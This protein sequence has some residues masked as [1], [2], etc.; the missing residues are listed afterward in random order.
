MIGALPFVLIFD[1]A[2]VETVVVLVFGSEEIGKFLDEDNVLPL[3]IDAD[4]EMTM[5]GI[6]A[7]IVSE[8]LLWDNN[9]DEPEEEEEGGG[10]AE[11]LFNGNSVWLVFN[12]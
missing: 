6:P 2:V 1:S 7:L 4:A 12:L 5:F 8:L 9:E 11:S 10:V 3:K